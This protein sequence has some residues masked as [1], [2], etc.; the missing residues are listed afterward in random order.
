MGWL[1]SFFFFLGRKLVSFKT[2]R[3]T[4]FYEEGIVDI[5]VSCRNNCLKKKTFTYRSFS[6]GQ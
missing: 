3:R 2:G 4:Y 1:V 6:F 5:H